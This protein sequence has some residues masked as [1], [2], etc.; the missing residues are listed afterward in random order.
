MIIQKILIQNFKAFKIQEVIDLEGKNALICGNNGSGKSSLHYALHVFLQSSLKGDAYKK[1]FTDPKDKV[2]GTESLLNIY[3][4]PAEFV[5]EL[6]LQKQ[7]KSKLKYQIKPTLDAGV[8]PHTHQDIVNA[9]FASDFISHRLLVNFYNFRNSQD[10]NL[11]TL[12]ENEVFPYWNDATK[13]KSFDKWIKELRKEAYDLSQVTETITDES[14]EKQTTRRKFNRESAEFKALQLKIADFNDSL[15]K[16]YSLLLPEVKTILDEFLPGENIE[17]DIA[18]KTPLDIDGNFFWNLPELILKI[19]A[20]GF[21]IPKPHI[22]L[23]EAKLTALALAVRLAMFSKKFKGTATGDTLKLLV[24][25]D[26]LVSLDMSFRMKLVKFIQEEQHKKDGL[27]KGY[28]IMMLTHD[29]GLFEILQ[30]TL[31]EDENKWK[32]FEFFETNTYSINKPDDYK[33]P[34]VVEKKDALNL[35]DEY[36]RGETKDKGGTKKPIPKDYELCALY[37]RKKSEQLIK[38]FYD[39]EMEG[40]FRYRILKDLSNG[41]SGLKNE[42][43]HQA[44][45]KIETILSNG[46]IDEA[47]IKKLIDLNLPVT[48]LTAAE[49]QENGKLNHFKKQVLDIVSHYYKTATNFKNQKKELEELSKEMNILR[50]RIMNKGAHHDDSPI[51]ELELRG[52]IDKLKEFE[53]VILKVKG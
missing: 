14:G 7:D 49:H 13:G 19:K 9:D 45:S 16:F 31:A 23:S 37:L 3:G 10:A 39:P 28:Q 38:R 24:L 47:K 8:L 44:Y 20:N 36:L 33:N 51:F 53:G 21:D 17:V 34:L 22:F 11:W 30:Q 46:E 12:F 18:Y 40:I 25:D 42:Y 32:S 1:Y 15:F 35:A 27:F 29:K 43:I 2:N 5:V 52:A 41:I 48:G 50:S 26:L 6:E 4:N